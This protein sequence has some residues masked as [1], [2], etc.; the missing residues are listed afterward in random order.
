MSR[1]SKYALVLA[2]LVAGTG[3]SSA[4]EGPYKSEIRDLKAKVLDLKGLPS[5]L[6]VTI[7]DLSARADGL[8]AQN[9]ALSV[10]R[11]ELA[12]R[13]SMMG[14]VLF[15]FDKANIQASAEPTLGDILRLIT[16]VPAGLITIEGHTDS[17]GPARYNKELSLKRANAVAEWL[18]AHGTDKARLSV[19]GLGDTRPIAPNTLESGADNPGGRALNRRVEFVLPRQ[20]P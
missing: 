8:A 5:D 13:V 6:G 15:E 11:D 20:N 16:S 1:A 9:S 3:F 18:A 4:E 2:V 10:R 17:K 12:V 19:K 7:S 14:D